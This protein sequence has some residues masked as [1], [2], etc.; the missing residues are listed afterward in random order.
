MNRKNGQRRAVVA[1]VATYAAIAIVVSLLYLLTGCKAQE[2]VVEKPVVVEHTTERHKVDIVRDT[3]VWRDSVYH[4]V[5]GDTVLIERWHHVANV[6]KTIVA[7]TVRDT[8]PVVTEVTRTEV[9]EVNVL[10]WWQTALMWMGGVLL[11]IAVFYAAV[12]LYIRNKGMSF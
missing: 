9:K 8:V 11:A 10:R 7:D 12:L 3:L 4:Y 2:I 1:I 5:K 6:S